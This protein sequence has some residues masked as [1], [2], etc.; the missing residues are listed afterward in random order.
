MPVRD[1]DEYCNA[2]R[3]FRTVCAYCNNVM[4]VHR[5]SRHW[6]NYEVKEV[7]TGKLWAHRHCEKPAVPKEAPC[8]KCK[9]VPG[10]VLTSSGVMCSTCADKD[11]THNY[12]ERTLL[13]FDRARRGLNALGVPIK[14]EKNE[15]LVLPTK[16]YEY[17]VAA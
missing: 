6:D 12:V 1:T 15:R 9:S 5:D 2:H 7:L 10:C 14:P 8:A 11:L 3:E 4:W 13:D 17:A 16:Q